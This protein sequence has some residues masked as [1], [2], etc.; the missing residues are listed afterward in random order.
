MFFIDSAR[1]DVLAWDYDLETA[2]IS[3]E[4]TV[5][6]LTANG[7]PLDVESFK[8]FLDGMTIDRYDNLYLPYPGIGQVR[9]YRVK[10]LYTA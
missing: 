10:S 7:Y 5:F 1:G 3:N 8:Y 4:R 2:E 9:C 6:N